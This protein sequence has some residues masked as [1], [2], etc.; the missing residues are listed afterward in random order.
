MSNA[1][2]GSPLGVTGKLRAVS[3]DDTIS[4]R[5]VSAAGA[6]EALA[7]DTGLE[8][9]RISVVFLFLG[10]RLRLSDVFVESSCHLSLIP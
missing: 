3:G 8:G 2:P 6:D 7:I 5:F 1:E 10:L 4:R 9:E